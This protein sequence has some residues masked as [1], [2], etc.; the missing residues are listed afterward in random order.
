MTR[1]EEGYVLASALAVL[2][3]LS[4]VAAALVA[5]SS[6][7]RNRSR[8]AE[9]D[10][11]NNLV[12]KSAVDVIGSQL[13]MDPR[14]RQL[15]TSGDR[16]VVDVLGRSVD[17]RLAWDNDKLDVNAAPIES[18]ESLLKDKVPDIGQ[19][20]AVLA[21]IRAK[22]AN[23][24]PARLLDDVL[25]VEV[26]ADCFHSILT[27]FGG[28]AEYSKEITPAREFGRPG[29][30]ARLS[31]DVRLADQSGPGLTAVVL[32]TGDPGAPAKVLDWR[33]SRGSGEE[34]CHDRQ[35]AQSQR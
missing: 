23:L 12:L 17:V 15:A 32:M 10:A 7:G 29:S 35:D 8:K 9:T 6:E 16:A 20:N 34:A 30:G 4:L 33:A 1:Q 14:R 28:Q 27:V 13:A 5:A 25:P 11:V 19:R 2:L 24:K 26:E 31:I 18:I 21:A 3:S 22:R